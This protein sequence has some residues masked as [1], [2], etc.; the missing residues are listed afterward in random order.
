[1]D[2]KWSKKSFTTHFLVLSFRKD[3]PNS[4]RRAVAL[5]ISLTISPL[6]GDGLD[7]ALIMVAAMEGPFAQCGISPQRI[8]ERVRTGSFGC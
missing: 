1:V 8:R 7:F 4:G 5:K 3:F 2:H 6:G